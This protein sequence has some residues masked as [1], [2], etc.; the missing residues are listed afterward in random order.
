MYLRAGLNIIS[1]QKKVALYAACAL[2]WLTGCGSGITSSGEEDFER[3][4]VD[5]NPPATPLS[6]EESIAKMQLPPGYRVE[7]VAS[8]PMVQEP[9]AIS[10]DGNGRMYVAEMNTYMKDAEG[11]GQFEKTSRIKLLEDT[12]GDGRMD[13]ATI[14]ADSLLLP[15]VV[16]PVGDQVLVQETNVQHIWSYRDT[17]GDGK[18]DEK[19]IV[20]RNDVLDVRNLEHQNGGL[21]W[22]LDNW[23]YPSRDNLRF[24]YKNGALVADT[25]VD[26]MIGQWGMTTNNYGQLFYSEAGPGLPAVQI[27]QMPAYGALNFKDQYTPEFAVPWPVIGTIDAQGGPDALRPDSTLSHFTSGCGQSIFRGDRLPADMQGDYFIPEPVGRIIKRGR[28]TNRDGKNY[29]DNVYREKDWLASADMNFRPI[30]TYTGPDGAFYIVDMYHGIIQESEWSGPGTY[31]HKIIQDKELYKNRG[32][33]RIYR[34]VHEDFKPDQKKPNMLN[35]PAAQLV[36]HLYH[37]NGWWRDNAQQLLIVRNDRSVIPALKQMAL[38]ESGSSKE[39]SNA[40]ARIHAL[41]TLEG[42]EAIDK[43]TLFSAFADPDPQVR[44]T[45]VWVSELF[46]KQNDQEVIDRVAALK[47]DASA[48]V[49]I[50]LMLSLRGNIS[51]KAQ[52]TVKELLAENPDNELMQYSY[53]TFAETQKVLAAERER[54]RNLGPADRELVTNGATIFKQLCS[55]CHGADGRGRQLGG[56]EMPAPPLVGSPR[57]KGD[58][59]LL[60][61]LM[62]NGLRG[63]VDGKTYPNMMPGM[64]HQDDEWIAAVVSYI[65]NS[66]ELGNNASIV[67]PGEVKTVRA[68]TPTIPEGMTL[69]MLEIFKLGRAERTNWG[70]GEDSDA[71]K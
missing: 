29:I 7:L 53:Q 43:K 10:W 15:R 60:L 27:Q 67:T 38:G 17:N 36:N 8:E 54:T 20:F 35:E 40:L 41:W 58:K 3:K 33:G 18:A 66:S 1:K 5:Q 37:P 68:N 9:V 46:I 12:N 61:Q 44:K 51:R 28:V 4:V 52:A 31:L 16:L 47:Q 50:Q 63:P 11:T 57:V 25:L 65:R 64:S 30:N 14:F 70:E 22:N 32:M 2:F 26:N 23:I 71:K 55:N 39:K 34:V 24:K 59:T 45:A 42:M 48:E 13:K 49:R 56:D 6:P 69:Q 62:L 21:L 19:K